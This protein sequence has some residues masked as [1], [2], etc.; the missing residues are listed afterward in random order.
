[1]LSSI[2]KLEEVISK[3]DPSKEPKFSKPLFGLSPKW[4]LAG[5]DGSSEYRIAAALASI[6][7]TGKVGPIRAN[8]ELVKYEN[9][10]FSWT[11]SSKQNCWAGNSLSARLVNVLRRRMMDAS[12]LSCENNPLYSL[13]SVS[14]RDIEAYITGN[15]DES[16]I[17]DLLFAFTWIDW[18]KN[19]D[20]IAKIMTVFA[21]DNF[22]F[23]FAS[24]A[25]CKFLFLPDL[26]KFI[27]QQIGEGIK[28]KYESAIIPLLCSGQVKK[29]CETAKNRLFISGLTPIN[30][31]YADPT[32][33]TKIGERIAAALLIPLSYSQIWQL[34]NQV[35]I[36][37]EAD[38]KIENTDSKNL[39]KA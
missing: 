9:K 27:K 13:L 10:K 29:A 32:G 24:Y 6:Q 18:N 12:R 31:S 16:L 35:I 17:E 8:L 5:Y 25:L 37:G 4:I 33:A 2:G 19:K 38:N 21:D 14:L 26:P 7:H 11:D 23:I 1:M 30:V 28:I 20:E 34:R 36:P 3:R 15:V 22:A 39:T